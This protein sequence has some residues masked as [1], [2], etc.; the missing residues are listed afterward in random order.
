MTN[1]ND[2]SNQHSHENFFAF[3]LKFGLISGLI[4][5]IASYVFLLVAVRI[6]PDLFTDYFNPVFNTSGGRDIFYY[7]HSFVL[8]FG[9]AILWYRFNTKLTGNF[10]L[11]GLEFG[12]L[13]LF[14]ALLPVMWI[15]F[16]AINVSISLIASWLIYGF[17]QAC[18]AG[19]IFALFSKK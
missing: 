10:I 7:L 6:Y 16:S 19:F 11:K 1:S 9:L 5:G 18:I 3:V 13:Y 17:V 12:I 4:I 2:H 14:I 15:T 8:G